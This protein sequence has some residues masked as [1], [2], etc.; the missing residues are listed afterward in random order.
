MAR[1]MNEEWEKKFCKLTLIYYN[2]LINFNYFTKAE[3]KCT[4]QSQ[5]C[6]LVGWLEYDGTFSIV[7]GNWGKLLGI[8][9]RV[10]ELSASAG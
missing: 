4:P 6:V 10:A 3:H 5:F 2:F 7:K 8:K 1:K 9:L